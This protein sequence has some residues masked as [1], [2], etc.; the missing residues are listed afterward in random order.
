MLA[1]DERPELVCGIIN[2]EGNFT[3]KDT[4]W[5]S[6]ITAQSPRE[7]SQQY[8]SMRQDAAAWITRCG[9]EPDAQRTDWAN[10]I[11]EHQ[12][13]QTLYAMSEALIAETLA[14][15]YLAAV[16][17]VVERGTP[18]HLIAGERSAEDWDTPDFIRKAARS[19]IEI[20]YAGHL[21]MLER[22][23]EFCQA[24]DAILTSAT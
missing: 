12:P 9:V 16:R 22:P 5:S 7:W 20:G 13:A 11:L 23:A 8:Q 4:F 15:D 2:V 19:Y 1:A 6:K 14:P 21:M 10:H 24:I 18:I 3:R 17:R